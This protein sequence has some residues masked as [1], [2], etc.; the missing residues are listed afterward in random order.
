[1]R[2]HKESHDEVR[3]RVAMDRTTSRSSET[4]RRDKST[5]GVACDLIVAEQRQQLTSTMVKNR[6]WRAA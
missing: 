2:H 3:E 6:V 5:N 4:G 1:M